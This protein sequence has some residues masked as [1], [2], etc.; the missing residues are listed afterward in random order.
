MADNGGID[1]GMGQTNIDKANG[2]RFGV[3]PMNDLTEFALS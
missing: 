2:I 1:Y 3:I